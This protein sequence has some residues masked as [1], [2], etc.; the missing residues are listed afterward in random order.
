M[1]GRGAR[2]YVIAPKPKLNHALCDIFNNMHILKQIVR[3][4]QKSH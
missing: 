1:G 2:K 3:E 4:T